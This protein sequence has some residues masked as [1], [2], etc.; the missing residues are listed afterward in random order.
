VI[1]WFTFD[2]HYI[3]LRLI[4]NYLYNQCLSPLK[5]S[6]PVHGEVYS[7]H[8]MIK[9]VSDLRQVGGFLMG[10]RFPPAIKLTDTI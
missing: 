7:I 2:L 6:N 10:L 9:F 8:Y 5:I 3:T 1:V 4:Y